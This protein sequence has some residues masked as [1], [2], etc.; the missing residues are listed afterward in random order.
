MMFA[1]V[2]FLL[3]VYIVPSATARPTP[4]RTQNQVNFTNIYDNVCKPIFL[5]E[6]GTVSLDTRETVFQ[7]LGETE[8]QKDCVK[9]QCKQFGGC[10]ENKFDVQLGCSW[11][12]EK[13][14]DVLKDNRDEMPKEI[15]IKAYNFIHKDAAFYTAVA[16]VCAIDPEKHSRREQQLEY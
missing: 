12:L 8:V 1:A 3:L 11:A 16:G 14:C 10:D 2:L 15:V 5:F 13:L 6:D 7:V 4:Y 9:E